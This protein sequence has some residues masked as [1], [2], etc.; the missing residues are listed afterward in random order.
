MPSLTTVRIPEGAEDAPVRQAL[1]RDF[2]LEI[3]GG[4]GPVRG[5]IWRIGL[6]GYSSTAANVLCFLSA[7]E[8]VLRGMGVP[9]TS[10]LEAASQSLGAA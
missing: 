2:G 1:L 8:Q 9:V 4:L 5:R 10:G 3:G 6:M 7:L